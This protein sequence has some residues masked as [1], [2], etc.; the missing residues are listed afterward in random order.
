MKAGDRSAFGELYERHLTQAR[1]VATGASSSP[2]AAE[3]AIQDGFEAVW[4]SRATYD[5]ARGPVAAWVMSIVRHRGLRISR[6]PGFALEPRIGAEAREASTDPDEVIDEA[7][8]DDDADQLRQAL[9]RL[10]YLQRE[11]IALAFYGQ[12][13]HSE[14]AEHL[15]LAPGTVKGRMRLGLDKLRADLRGT[16]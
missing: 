16:G 3:E 12:L 4:R 13:S 15:E 8:A 10:P 1:R 9:G 11:V 2:G 7:L 5:A 14:I 6:R